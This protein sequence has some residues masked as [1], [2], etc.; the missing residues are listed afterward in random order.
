MGR[1]AS[2]CEALEM[3]KWFNTNYHY[4]VPELDSNTRFHLNS[5]KIISE[6]R[7]ASALGITPKI[8]IIG[9]LTFL[10]L[11]KTQDGSDPFQFLPLILTLYCQLMVELG[12]LAKNIVIQIDEPILV[13]DLPEERL[14]LLSEIY[15][16]LVN[17]CPENRLLVMT[18]FDQASE[19]VRELVGSS[20]WGIGR[21]YWIL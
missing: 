13:C 6:F 20:I 4:F 1:G 10:S 21:K 15:N 2:D 12:S 8:N 16:E 14:S 5:Q 11:A 9:P 7:E 17:V 19:A 3:T 18:Y